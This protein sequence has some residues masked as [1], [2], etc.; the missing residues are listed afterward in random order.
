MSNS[1]FG[2]NWSE[3]VILPVRRVGDHWEFFYG[4]DI[5]VHEGSLAE[6]TLDASSISNPWFLKRVSQKLEI[7]VLPIGA[8]LLVALSDR[9]RGGARVGLWPETPRGDIPTGT[10]RFEKIWIGPP[11]KT[12]QALLQE[13][14]TGGL[15][16][17]LKGLERTE[18]R[19]S[20]IVM[21]EGFPATTASSLN[22]AFTLLS[23]EYE[24]HRISNTGNV[25]KQCFYQDSDSKWYPL[26]DL[27]HGV[28][29]KGER[30]L[31]AS[32]WAE[33]EQALGWRPTTSKKPKK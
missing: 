17:R 32:A 12:Q 2:S 33:I 28:Q 13:D 1:D 24:T 18:I 3:K 22:H 30:A 20:T 11:K 6:L 25:Y 8:P 27:R 9:S 4:G 5:P 29:V 19:S 14:Q 10:T 21:P 23:K 7:K 16:L 15:W 26:S 31:L